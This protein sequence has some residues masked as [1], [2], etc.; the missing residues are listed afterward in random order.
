MR[1]VYIKVVQIEGNCPE[2]SIGPEQPDNEDKKK[3]NESSSN[4]FAIAIT[5]IIVILVLIIIGCIIYL[6]CY[7]N[8]SSIKKN[9]NTDYYNIGGKI[10][11]FDD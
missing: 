3:E 1:L 6:K 10:I 7:Q 8:R 5:I 4:G 2:P 11:P 9:D